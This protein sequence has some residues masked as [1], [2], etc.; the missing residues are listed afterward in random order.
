MWL[1]N[2]AE[3]HRFAPPCR[4]ADIPFFFTLLLLWL[5]LLLWDYC[6]FDGGSLRLSAAAYCADN[7]AAP[8]LSGAPRRRVIYFLV[9]IMNIK[10]FSSNVQ[11]WEERAVLWGR[12][13]TAPPTKNE[14]SVASCFVIRILWQYQAELDTCWFFIYLVVFIL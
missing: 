12:P 9:L 5:W 8:L 3:V 1:K 4:I 11:L 13:Q 10:S 7:Y 2:P 14:S 6:N